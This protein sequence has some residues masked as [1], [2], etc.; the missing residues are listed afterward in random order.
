[1]IVDLMAFAEAEM[2][3]VIGTLV[4]I[5]LL[6]SVT[7]YLI[8]RRRDRPMLGVVLGGVLS[9]P[10]LLAILLMPPKEADFY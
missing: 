7:G 8:G 1:M 5:V 3:L 10:G 9:V 2:A 4:G 6:G